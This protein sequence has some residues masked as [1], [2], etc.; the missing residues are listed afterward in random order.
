MLY[1]IIHTKNQRLNTVYSNL[2]YLNARIAEE[3]VVRTSSCIPEY[4][5]ITNHTPTPTPTP[6]S[7]SNLEKLF[8]QILNNQN[9]LL[10]I[11]LKKNHCV[12]HIERDGN[13]MR[14][15]QDFNFSRG[16]SELK[17]LMNPNTYMNDIRSISRARKC[18]RRQRRQNFPH[19]NLKT[20]QFNP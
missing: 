18:R 4:N 19:G 11:I 10:G 15:D 6:N 14:Y 3:E 13:I 1:K 9:E 17:I 2:K 7:N 12:G 20:S 16:D 8:V 5:H